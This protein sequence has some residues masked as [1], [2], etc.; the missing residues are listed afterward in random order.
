MAH[1]LHTEITYRYERWRAVTS[2]ILE[3]ATSTFLLLIAVRWFEAGALAKALVA[4]GGRFGLL[5]SP[6]VVAVVSTRGWPAAE[7]ASGLLVVG[8]GRI[9][10][11]ALW[12]RLPV[13]VLAA[14]VV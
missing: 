3:S 7:A 12:S 14:G 8:A 6:L 9:L 13:F 1:P 2:G 11:A 4:G 5:L 10:L